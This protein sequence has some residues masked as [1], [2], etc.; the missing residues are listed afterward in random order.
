MAVKMLNFKRKTLFTV[1]FTIAALAL[2]ASVIVTLMMVFF[3]SL[4]S[5]THGQTEIAVS[6]RVANLQK[7]VVNTLENT[8][9]ILFNTAYGIS[10]LYSQGEVSQQEM[11]NYFSPIA[12]LDSNIQM[13]YF[14]S[15]NLWYEPNGFWASVPD[16]TPPPGWDNTARPWFI[17]AKNSPL[18]I[19]YSEPYISAFSG[20]IVV[21]LSTEVF[22][23]N[24]NSIGVIGIDVLITDLN[25]LLNTST[26]I[27]EQ[28]LYML[29]KDGFFITHSN[30]EAIMAKNFFDESPFAKY[31]NEILSYAV[32]SKIDD[33]AYFYSVRI[34]AAGWTIVSTI[35]ASVIYAEINSLILRLSILSF[36]ILAGIA[37]ISILFTYRLMG[38]QNR[39]LKALREK[40]ETAN[41]IKSDFLAKMSHEIRTPMNAI[42]GMA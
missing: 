20:D 24:K 39:N 15:N 17:G 35:P 18:K 11:V 13:L 41:H 29:N 14:T 7:S 27:A 3:I 10:A 16:W 1:R 22:D 23:K 26:I 6:E 19:A 31:K 9:K 5:V 8:E 21:A 38:S 36:A 30:N 2:A 32:F 34:P 33:S 28:E 4:R 25:T 12:K 42:T 37:V 40:A